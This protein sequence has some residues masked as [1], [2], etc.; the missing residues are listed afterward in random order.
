MWSDV[1]TVVALLFINTGCKKFGL[2]GCFA[3]IFVTN[4]LF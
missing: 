4:Q 3:T 1:I 2:Q